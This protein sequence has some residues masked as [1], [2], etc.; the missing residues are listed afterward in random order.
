MSIANKAAGK[1]VKTLKKWSKELMKTLPFFKNSA[2]LFSKSLPTQTI[3]KA[4]E[5]AERLTKPPSLTKSCKTKNKRIGQRMSKSLG[6]GIDPVKLIEEFGADAV[7]F[8]IA[9]QIMGN[10]DIKFVTDNILMGKKFCNKIWNASRF[11]LL[12]IDKNCDNKKPVAKTQADKVILKQLDKTIKSVN[13]DLNNF[14]FGKS[15]HTLYDFFWHDFCDGYIEKSKK[16][17]NENTNKILLYVLTNSLLLLHP[18]M[19]FITEEIYQQLPIKNKQKCLM[20]ES[21]PK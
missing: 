12:K 6:T 18:F 11:V 8:G 17:D 5:T 20:I 14:E 21:W 10:Q 15:A 1:T 2:F 9:F 7:R 19:P 3:I 16:Q 13:K 4:D